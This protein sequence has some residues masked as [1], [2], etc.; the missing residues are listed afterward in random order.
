MLMVQGEPVPARMIPFA[1]V[2]A[3]SLDDRRVTDTFYQT[4]ADVNLKAE[5]AKTPNLYTSASEKQD[6]QLGRRMEGQ[7]KG[8]E[9]QLQAL[10]KQRKLA[11][12]RNDD[13]RVKALTAQEQAVQLRF[14]TA[15]FKALNAIGLATPPTSN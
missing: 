11:T 13:A 2:F 8:A 14:N 7:L 4:R 1:R 3:G 10:R 5:M 6:M 9:H 15:Y 12:A